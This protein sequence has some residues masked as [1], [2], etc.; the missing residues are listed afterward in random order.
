MP[1]SKRIVNRAKKV[2]KTSQRKLPARNG[3]G[4]ECQR[5][6]GDDRAHHGD[7][8]GDRVG[9]HQLLSQLHYVAISGEGDLRRQEAVAVRV[10]CV[11]I[12]ERHGHHQKDGNKAQKGVDAQRTE[13]R[14]VCASGQFVAP[15]PRPRGT[16]GRSVPVG[17]VRHRRRSSV[18]AL[19]ALIGGDRC[20]GCCDI[21]SGDGSL[22]RPVSFH[23]T[24]S[25]THR[26]DWSGSMRFTARLAAITM[27]NP[28]TDCRKPA[29]AAMP[30]F[31]R[32]V[33]ALKT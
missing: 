32:R 27:M 6:Q 21:V 2:K 25:S 24:G 20:V 9:L 1:P 33:R 5:Q 7:E 14:R 26:I 23:A 19:C 12:G 13:Y 30:M 8:D 15:V 10:E 17:G 18:A 28:T 3:V 29:A 11:L 16:P 4:K 22:V 31:P